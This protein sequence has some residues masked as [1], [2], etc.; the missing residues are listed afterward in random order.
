MNAESNA[1]LHAI[2]SKTKPDIQGVVVTTPLG[3]PFYKKKTSGAWG[4]NSE[5]N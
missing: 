5:R 1:I 3:S 4:L 2:I